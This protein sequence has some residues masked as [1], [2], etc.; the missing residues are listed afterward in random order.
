MHYL[1]AEH[2]ANTDGPVG[3]TKMKGRNFSNRVQRVKY[4]VTD[5]VMASLAFLL[6][7]IF[8][9]EALDPEKINYSTLPEFLF[10]SKL[11]MEQRLVPSGM[12]LLF[13]LSGFYNEP[14]N[15]SRLSE[16]TTT[17]WS[18]LLSTLIIFFALL[19]NDTSGI[20]A[21]DYEMILVLFGLIFIFVYAGRRI[22]SLITKDHL[23]RRRW[24]YSTLIIGNSPKSRDIFRKLRRRG[25]VWAYD[26]IGFISLEGE[27]QVDDGQK[28]WVWDEVENVCR[29]Y[30]IDQIILAPETIRDS[31]IMAI[32]KRLFPLECPVKITP[33]TLSYITGNIRLDDILGIPFIDLTSPRISE[34]QKNVKRCIDVGLS[35]AGLIVLSPLLLGAA[36]AVK[37]TSPGP[38]I[39]RQER[40]GKG[41]RPF[42]IY[43]FRSMREDSEKNGPQLSNKDDDRITPWGKV[44]RKYRIDELPQLWNVL[45]GDMSLV[46]PRPERAFYIDRIVRRA[47]YYG[48]IFQVRPGITSWGMVKHGYASNVDEMVERSQYDLLYLNNMSLSTDMKIMIHTVNTII[49]GRGV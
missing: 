8:R 10:S 46:G 27:R 42:R 38:V 17:L 30:R 24:I 19:I 39:Y 34:F 1:F 6:F 25:S 26:V 32:L 36:I 49:K 43:K 2:V 31:Q 16:L 40:I 29:E 35:I 9:F 5:F 44:M 14:F 20:K 47:P 33:D 28:T 4:V 22:L 21:R 13:W 23:K 48:L 7:N 12:L 45:K 11:L 15:K 18:S 3:K 41:R 37:A